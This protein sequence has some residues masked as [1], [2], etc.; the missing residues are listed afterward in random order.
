MC[1]TFFFNRRNLCG[2]TFV[3]CLKLTCLLDLINYCSNFKCGLKAGDALIKLPS[4]KYTRSL[5]SLA[6]YSFGVPELF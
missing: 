6:C 5:A 3:T 4:H 1:I 2:L